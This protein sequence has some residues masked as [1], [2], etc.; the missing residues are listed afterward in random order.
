MR[1]PELSARAGFWVVAAV[2]LVVLAFSTVPTPLYGIYQRRDGFAVYVITVIFAAYAVGVMAALYLAGH[3]S[4]WAGRRRMLLLS[5]AIQLASV[6]VFLVRTDVP[7][8]IVARLLNGVGVGLMTPTATAYLTELWSSSRPGASVSRATLVSTVVNMGGLSLG[9]LVSGYLAQYVRSPLRVPYLVFLVL[10]VLGTAA[11]FLVP[12]TVD[13]S[14]E[15]PPYRPQRIAL[16]DGQRATFFGAAVGA[17]GGFAIL[18]LFTSLAP[19][20]VT[21]IMHQSSHLVAGVVTSVVFASGA[22][23]QVVF[24][25]AAVRR[26]LQLGSTLMV[27]ALVA[28]AVA[29]ELPS[30]SLF[31]AAAVLGG[32]GVGLVFRSAIAT[33]AGLAEPGARGEVL[34]AAFLSA[35]A[36]LAVPVLLVGVAISY[37]SAPTTLVVF[38]AAVLVLV[39]WSGNRMLAHYRD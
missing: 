21:G 14:G 26:Q 19:T 23:A 33:A 13:T 10:L 34:A 36:G 22:L 28:M 29:G 5:L 9:P 25:R 15:H 16:P 31:I 27:A 32:A 30:L 7:G 18:G 12:E 3:I 37:L 39:A 6:A 24:S 38:A 20:L 8:L 17:F 35:Y 4:D 11:T 1:R 2:F